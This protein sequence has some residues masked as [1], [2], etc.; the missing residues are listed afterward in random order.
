[1]K[2]NVTL[3]YFFNKLSCFKSFNSFL[4]EIF[5]LNS[6]VDNLNNDKKSSKFIIFYKKWFFLNDFYFYVVDT[7]YIY[8]Y[9]Y[10]YSKF[11]LL[12][13]Y[14]NNKINLKLTQTKSNFIYNLNN[15][16]YNQTLLLFS[17]GLKSI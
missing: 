7:L 2:D 12:S 6:S 1:M 15:G 9:Y 5:F 3:N 17:Y 8:M 13:F 10:I 16:D 4:D 14:K 11:T